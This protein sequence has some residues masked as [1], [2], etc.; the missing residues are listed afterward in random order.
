MTDSSLKSILNN[1]D[2]ALQL[3]LAPYPG[4]FFSAQDSPLP[5]VAEERGLFSRLMAGRIRPVALA[6]PRPVMLLASRDTY[7]R[8]D[9][10]AS[11]LANPD[12]DALWQSYFQAERRHPALQVLASQVN[13]QGVL[14]PFPPLFTC[15]LKQYFF[16]PPCPRCGGSLALCTDDDL[17]AANG[18]S[19]YTTS[20]KRYLFCPGC[21]QAV[22]YAAAPEEQPVVHGPDDLIRQWGGLSTGELPCCGCGLHEECY[23]HRSLVL[24]RIAPVAFFPFYVLIFDLA[25][26]SA[27]DFLALAAGT[28]FIERAQGLFTEREPEPAVT[29]PPVEP[30]PP[31]G[32]AEI[33]PAVEPVPDVHAAEIA[34]ILGG[35]RARWEAAGQAAPPESP[36]VEPAA[37]VAGPDIF[38]ETVVLAP[39]VQSGQAPVGEEPPVPPPAPPDEDDFRTET[40]IMHHPPRV[41][42]PV[43]PPVEDFEQTVVMPAAQGAPTPVREPV[44]AP[45]PDLEATVIMGAP[46]QPKPAPAQPAPSAPDEMSETVVMGA[47]ARPAATAQPSKPSTDD[48][49]LAETVILKPKK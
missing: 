6:T 17:L 22:F 30:L 7:P 12:I 16:E 36:A 20:L 34:R 9:E 32:S 24:E 35:I 21:N 28:P 1:S 43:T 37:V 13:P 15:R 40:I 23:G 48:D 14:L 33:P 41:S 5:L 11:R 2:R 38:Q 26:L 46:P 4:G 29:I 31:Q 8:I 42:T 44:P 27:L 3:E 19:A 18:L 10:A 39:E 45:V 47:P 25:A 49:A